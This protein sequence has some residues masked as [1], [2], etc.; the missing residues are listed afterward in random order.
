MLIPFVL[1]WL[2]F[3]HPQ[4]LPE[5]PA[6]RNAFTVIAHRGNHV[7]APENTL[8]AY[9]HAIDCGAD[10]I[11]TDLRTS[12]DGQLVIMHDN[13][14]NRTTNGAGKVKELSWAALREIRTHGGHQVPSFRE[15]LELCKGRIHIY[16]DFKDA[17][18]KATVAMIRETGMEKQVLVYINSEAQYKAWRSI[19]PQIPL[20]LSLPDTVSDAATLNAFLDA[21]PVSALDGNFKQYSRS[22]VDAAA[23]RGV[24][25][26]PDIQGP[27]EG[28][29][30][31]Q[32]AAATGLR[33]L[34]TDRPAALVDYLRA[35]GLR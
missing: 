8:A 34:Q 23:K 16:L 21:H 15:V 19:A 10:Y 24:A 27:D 11:E 30:L 20:M 32:Q 25:V 26:W 4:T 29:A 7:N 13:T 35:A 12:S 17:D 28:P 33:G 14:V 2:A 18:V 3:A 5:L 1:S 22:M 9:Q 6:A 31:W